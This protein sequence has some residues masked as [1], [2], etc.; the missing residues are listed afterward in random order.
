MSM[1]FNNV[2]NNKKL[3]IPGD[4]LEEMINEHSE[5]IM[6]I[7]SIKMQ[8]DMIPDEEK[9]SPDTYGCDCLFLEHFITEDMSED[10]SVIAREFLIH[11][12]QNIKDH[13][14][15]YYVDTD[16]AKNWPDRMFERFILN[17]MMNAVNYGS[18]Y[19]KN[20]FLYLHRTYYS[21]E[22]KQ[23]KKFSSI[24]RS[25]LFSL[26]SDGD[27]GIIRYDMARILTIAKMMG[28]DIGPDCYC[29][30]LYLND[31]HKA[32][33]EYEEPDWGFMDSVSDMIP[34]HREENNR[35][36]KDRD[37]MLDMHWKYDKF[38]ENVQ[39]I[40]IKKLRV[41]LHSPQELVLRLINC[42]KMKPLRIK[43]QLQFCNY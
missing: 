18:Q 41:Q 27:G 36:F 4:K 8:D 7:L 21:R 10:F 13:E 33:D 38:L 14:M 19:T 9:T 15:V 20:L 42:F 24:S 26:A 3:T 30:Y 6:H 25:E 34:E 17:F 29:A 40:C 12:Y 37:E 11:E 16:A 28:I 39:A 32:Y 23:L 22:Y 5:D 1:R 2:L 35:I 43:T 31:R